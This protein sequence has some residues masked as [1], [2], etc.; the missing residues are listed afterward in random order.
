MQ[1][2]E[3]LKWLCGAIR[4]GPAQV[5][6]ARRR[7]H[8]PPE[9]LTTLRSHHGR[10]RPAWAEA[11]SMTSDGSSPVTAGVETSGHT[12]TSRIS[13]RTGRARETHRPVPESSPSTT[14]A[15]RRRRGRRAPHRSRL[16][17]RGCFPAAS[18]PSS[19]PPSSK[20]ASDFGL[21]LPNFVDDD[22]RQAPGSLMPERRI[23]RPRAPC[24]SIRYYTTAIKRNLRQKRSV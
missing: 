3:N 1:V 9:S 2:R 10:S 8:A 22:A 18:A 23:W 4:N 24:A 6:A 14:S 12:R 7:E 5:L 17:E 11:R 13:G 20:Q 21:P 15:R 16:V 19:Q